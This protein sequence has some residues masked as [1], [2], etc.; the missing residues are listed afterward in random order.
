MPIVRRAG[1]DLLDEITADDGENGTGS[2]ANGNDSG[3]GSGVGNAYGLGS[4]VSSSENLVIR[5]CL[6]NYKMLFAPRT[7]EWMTKSHPFQSG[8]KEWLKKTEMTMEK[9]GQAVKEMFVSDNTWMK[10]AKKDDVEAAKEEFKRAV[11]GPGAGGDGDGPEREN[12]N[13]DNSGKGGD[14]EMADVS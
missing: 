6:E 10:G 13:I 1:Y 3:G 2:G 12:M 4:L 7:D 14:E 5:V 9:R 11:K 8:G